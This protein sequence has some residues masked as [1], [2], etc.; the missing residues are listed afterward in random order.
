MT[1]PEINSG[2]S[3]FVTSALLDAL[4]GHWWLLR[5]RGVAAIVFGLLV[6]HFGDETRRALTY[7]WGA[8]SVADGVLVL[9]FA[10]TGKAGTPRQ[11]LGLVGLAGLASAAMAF[12]MPAVVAAWLIVFVAAWAIVTG[13][14][15]VAGAIQL[16]KVVEADWILALDGLMA[17]AFGVALVA[18]PR[19]AGLALVWL[20]GWFGVLLGGLY[21]AI[22]Y[23]L[24][25]S[26]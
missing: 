16:R 21:V 14:M 6:F 3:A 26:R 19:V 8:Y 22:G 7:L 9:W 18:W 17:I 11:W 5:L 15:Q 10:V 20:V 24:R 23:W 13:M 2:Q 4:S 1:R 25:R 12:T